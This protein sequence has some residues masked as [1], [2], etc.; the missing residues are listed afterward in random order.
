MWVGVLIVTL[1]QS[2]RLFES[3]VWGFPAP[4][5]AAEGL[6]LCVMV[7]MWFRSG[8]ASEVQDSRTAGV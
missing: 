7:W 8:M 3:A 6:T 2:Q 1:L 4:V 5:L